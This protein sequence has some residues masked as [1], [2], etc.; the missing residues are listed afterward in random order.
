MIVVKNK[1]KQNYEDSQVEKLQREKTITLNRKHKS[2]KDNHFTDGS[3][4][5]K[6]HRDNN[7]HQINR[8]LRNIDWNDMD[9][10]DDYEDSDYDDLYN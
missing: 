10:Y 7:R 1:T 5:K 2:H 4:K 3:S 6:N 8:Q 9:N